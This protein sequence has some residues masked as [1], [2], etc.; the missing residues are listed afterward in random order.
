MEFLFDI[1]LVLL[2]LLVMMLM[3]CCVALSFSAISLFVWEFLREFCVRIIYCM[4]KLF[5]VIHPPPHTLWALRVSHLIQLRSKW[6]KFKHIACANKVLC[7]WDKKS[8]EIRALF[9]KPLNATNSNNWLRTCVHY[10][11][12]YI[13]KRKKILIRTKLFNGKIFNEI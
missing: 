12:S 8:A 3:A 9:V 13:H 4:P 1:L 2:M 7:G 11:H 10:T 6:R 5:A